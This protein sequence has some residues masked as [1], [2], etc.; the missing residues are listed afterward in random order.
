MKRLPTLLA[1]LL[2]R[3]RYSILIAFISR[4]KVVLVMTT[5]LA[6]PLVCLLA[7]CGASKPSTADATS[8]IKST[9]FYGTSV[10]NGRWTLIDPGGKPYFCLGLNHLNQRFGVARIN[11]DLA[12]YNFNSYGWMASFP[13][14]EHGSLSYL[15]PFD[16]LNI[17]FG[18]YSRIK[19]GDTKGTFRYPDI[20]D[21]AFRAGVVNTVADTCARLKNDPNLVAYMLG[22][23]PVIIPQRDNPELNWAAAIRCQK[24]GTP[25]KLEY[26]AWIRKEYRG[27]GAEFAA[28][29]GFALKEDN[30]TPELATV[31]PTKSEVYKDDVRFALHLIDDFYAF[32]GPL[33]RKAD[34]NHLLFS[35]RLQHAQLNTELLRFAARH[36][37]AIA[38]QPPFIETF[39]IELYR[40]VHEITGKPIFISDHHVT[41]SSRLKTRE[42]AAKAWVHYLQAMYDSRIVIGYGFCSHVD[43]VGK[44]SGLVKPGLCDSSGTIHPEFA[45]HLVPANRQLLEKF[46]RQ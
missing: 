21:T 44:S 9:G 14:I 16:F 1:V 39:D 27:R 46:N 7:F 11:R 42:D 23:V 26:L 33:I 13:F 35:H 41:T 5:L 17:S 12:S 6:S 40:T 28:N 38:I 32:V 31:S 36:V 2:A 25:G 4:S 37:D 30:F 3:M 18:L 10:L 45:R 24:D 22:D 43:S 20:Y 15:Y 29:Y 19:R 8:P 34:P